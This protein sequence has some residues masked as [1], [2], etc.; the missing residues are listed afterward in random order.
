MIS[1][2]VTPIKEEPLFLQS[3]I[4][5]QIKKDK[6]LNRFFVRERCYI[7]HQSYQRTG[8]EPLKNHTG[9]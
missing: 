3:Y 8:E 2:G 7:D 6:G 1:S 9:A 4:K 5:R